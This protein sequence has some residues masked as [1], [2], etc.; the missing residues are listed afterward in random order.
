MSFDLQK[1]SSFKRSHFGFL[2]RKIPP[3][4]MSSRL[5]LTFFSIRLDFMCLVLCL[6][7]SS[8]WTWALCTVSNMSLYLFLSVQTASYKTTTYIRC[9]LFSI[10]YFWFLCQRSSVHR[11]VVL[12]LHLQFNFI[13]QHAYLC[14]NTIQLFLSLFQCSLAWSQGCW[15]PQKFFNFW[16]F[17]FFPET[18]YLSK[19]LAI[20]ELTLYTR[21]TS[22]SE[23]SLP[24][25]PDCWD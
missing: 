2:F 20:L 11:C 7:R 15:F 23:I 8:T 14:P 4:S 19:S 22:N 17:L 12:F 1:L 3:V 13:F 16:F 10:V 6:G 21:L 9:F 25:P 5:F 18:G 24:L